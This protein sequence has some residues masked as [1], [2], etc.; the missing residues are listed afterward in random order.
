MYQCPCVLAHV[1]VRTYAR[2][3]SCKYVRVGACVSVCVRVCTCPRVRVRL[4][5]ETACD[6]GTARCVLKCNQLPQPL[7]G[8][9]RKSCNQ[10]RSTLWSKTQTPASACF[11]LAALGGSGERAVHN[12]RGCDHK[13]FWQRTTQKTA[14]DKKLECDGDVL[15][16]TA[17]S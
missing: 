3:T 9:C 6:G 17:R 13:C 11:L 8:T 7:E 4:T 15:P 10:R 16:D 5:P 12:A 2:V 14:H 1:S